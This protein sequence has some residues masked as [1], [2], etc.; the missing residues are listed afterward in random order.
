MGCFILIII[1]TARPITFRRRQHPPPPSNTHDQSRGLH[2]GEFQKCRQLN[3]F[4]GLLE[5]LAGLG[6][7]A[8][9]RLS[10]TWKDGIF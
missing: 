1:I 5:I 7:V 8:V 9:T 6:N 4:N 2:S 10:K 3:N